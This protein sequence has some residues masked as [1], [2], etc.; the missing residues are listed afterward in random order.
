MENKKVALLEKEVNVLF[1]NSVDLKISNAETLAVGIDLKDNLK[2][3]G[4][5]IKETKEGITKPMNLALKNTRAMFKPAETYYADAVKLVKEKI[6][7]YVIAQEEK[8]A[9]KERAI[10]EKIESGAIN[11]EEAEMKIEKLKEVNKEG[12]TGKMHMTTR[13]GVEITDEAQIPR[14]YLSL[15]MVLIRKEALAGIEIPGVKVVVT[16][17]VV[18]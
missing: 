4:K 7:K 3:K 1:K 6:G 14:K 9:E 8:K 18:Q 10:R 15:N 16:R 11:T 2:A 17:D 5:V 12:E 13:K